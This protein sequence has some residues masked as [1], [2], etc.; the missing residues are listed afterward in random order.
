MFVVLPKT[1]YFQSV[2]KGSSFSRVRQRRSMDSFRFWREGIHSDAACVC[3]PWRAAGKHIV[4]YFS[5]CFGYLPCKIIQYLIFW[6]FV[7][8]I[9]LG[10][11]G[12]VRRSN[13]DVTRRSMQ[14][15]DNRFMEY[16]R[17]CSMA[18][19]NSATSMLAWLF[20]LNRLHPPVRASHIAS[21]THLKINDRRYPCHLRNKNCCICLANLRKSSAIEKY[22]S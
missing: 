16:R 15:P 18:P 6:N 22:I 2:E 19:W 11:Q 10:C 3:R 1:C 12:M 21:A 7:T 20:T 14:G 17:T 5:L 9:V 4:M 8:A 13:Y